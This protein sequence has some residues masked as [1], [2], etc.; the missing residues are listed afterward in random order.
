MLQCRRVCR[1]LDSVLDNERSRHDGE[2]TCVAF[3]P[4]CRIDPVQC[5][6]QSSR[7]RRLQ[8]NRLYRQEMRAI[9]FS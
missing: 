2:S 4:V 5:C 6:H 7:I 3:K 8:Y 1:L 9:V